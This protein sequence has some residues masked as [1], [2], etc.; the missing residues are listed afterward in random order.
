MTSPPSGNAAR[1]RA[2]R[3]SRHGASCRCARLA[4]GRVSPVCTTTQLG[5]PIAKCCVPNPRV[6][7]LPV[8]APAQAPAHLG[9]G[10]ALTLAPAAR[11]RTACTHSCVLAFTAVDLDGTDIYWYERAAQTVQCATSTGVSNFMLVHRA[12]SCIYLQFK[13]R[14]TWRCPGSFT[15]LVFLIGVSRRSVRSRDGK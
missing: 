1:A 11:Y 15:L 13:I 3:V 10:M 2:E 6:P 5:L 14:R 7:E 4:S 9:T 12:V 8:L